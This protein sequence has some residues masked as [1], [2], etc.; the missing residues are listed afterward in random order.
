MEM[1]IYTSLPVGTGITNAAL[2]EQKCKTLEKMGK[3]NVADYARSLFGLTGATT[4]EVRNQTKTLDR[5]SKNLIETMF[6]V[7]LATIR[8]TAAATSAIDSTTNEIVNQI[9]T[10]KTEINK[11]LQPVSSAT[12]QT[13]GTLTNVV[14][15]PLGS[16]F[17][18]PQSLVSVVDKVNPG[19]ANR[20]DATLKKYKANDLTNVPSQVIGGLK[21]LA[22]DID[23][24]LAVPF[25]MAEDLYVGLMTIMEDIANA[26]D[27]I[28][29]SIIDLFLGPDGVLDSIVPFT[30]I[31]EL[32]DVVNGLAGEISSITGSVTGL[33]QV[34]DY[35]SVSQGLM[36]QT[37]SIMSNPL[38]LASAYIPGE[39]SNYASYIRDPSQI[40]QGLIP[41][42]YLSQFQNIGSIPGLGFTGNLGYGLG[43]I[44]EIAKQ[45]ILTTIITDF[46]SQLGI[47]SPMLG[48]Q[49]TQP[50]MTNTQQSYVP[51][52][53]PSSINPAITV[54]QT[55]VPVQ[56]TNTTPVMPVKSS[57]SSNLLP[58]SF[59]KTFF[60]PTITVSTNPTTTGTQVD[61][62]F[63][64]KNPKQFKPQPI[65]Q[66]TKGPQN[67]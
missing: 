10:L 36:L 34:N 25:S 41:A 12:G 22:T 54:T 32:L 62:D 15:D 45:G 61:F 46:E 28:L 4:D 59:T 18:L 65:G 53:V 20:L 35:L 7:E 11:A 51:A 58:T 13:L 55:G 3:S 16:A 64:N 1:A 21:S 52:T 27:A 37:D 9:S 24:A 63:F 33:T 14:Q 49:Q 29:A 60:E 38:N 6:S 50:P 19:F 57:S 23:K 56:T 39:A 5:Y 43:G 17:A 48:I 67:N 26:L 40:V 31:M 66:T 44:F 8:G 47:L 42:E 30:E 2:T